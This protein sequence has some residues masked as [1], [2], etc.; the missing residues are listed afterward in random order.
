MK[1]PYFL[2]SLYTAECML[3]L[4]VLVLLFFFEGVLRVVFFQCLES[5]CYAVASGCSTPPLILL[6]RNVSLS[7]KVA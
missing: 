5:F 1:H 4:F 7:G 2:N 6:L 3:I